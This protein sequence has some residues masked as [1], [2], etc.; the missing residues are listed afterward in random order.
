IEDYGYQLGRHWQ[1][2][3]KEKN[4]GALLIV[5][6]NERKVRIEVGYGFEGTLTDAV[7]KLIIEN[8]ILPRLRANDFASGLGRGVD[9]IIQ[10]VWVDSEEWKARAKQRPDDEP[11]LLDVLAL[12]FFL[13]I[14]F[15]IVRSVAS[16]GRGY[17]QTG[18]RPQRGSRGPIFIPIPGS[19]GSSGSWSGGFPGGGFSGGGGSFGGAGASGS[20]LVGRVDGLDDAAP[21]AAGGAMISDVDKRRLAEAIRA[22]EEKTAGEIFCV[23]A[24]ACGN[25]RLVPIA[26][27]ALVAL[28]VPLPLIFLTARPAG[29]IYLLQL[30]AFIVAALVLSLPMIR[31]RIVP[32]RRLWGRVHAEAMHQFLAQ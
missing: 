30:A 11:G 9:D 15:M 3:Q 27:A 16:R 20:F 17:A 18:A 1:I 25:Y 21:R 28:A 26:W 24:H 32:E 13:F 22:A 31:F 19:W 14:L 7:S 4:T 6:P 5:A 2:G 8:S 10:A 29:I 23:I 12:L